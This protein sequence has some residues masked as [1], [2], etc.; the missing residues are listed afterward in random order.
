M[1]TCECGE[2]NC[3]FND[4]EGWCTKQD[5]IMLDGMCEEF[6]H[7]HKINEMSGIDGYTMLLVYRL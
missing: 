3:K 6:Y 5:I 7:R 2:T 1:R 4:D